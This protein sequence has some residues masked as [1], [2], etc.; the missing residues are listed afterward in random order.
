MD[1]NKFNKLREKI[2]KKDF[3]GKNENLD[4]WLYRF[5][6]FG[7]VSS[8]FFAIFLVFPALYKAFNVY[9]GF[10]IWDIIL[11][12]MTTFAFLVSFEVIK[13][14]LIRNFSHDLCLNKNKLSFKLVGWFI[15]SLSIITL[16]FYLSINGSKNLAESTVFNETKHNEMLESKMDSIYQ[17]Y[18]KLR[19]PY[20]DEIEELRKSNRRSREIQASTTNA[21]ERRENEKIISNNEQI[22]GNYEEKLTIYSNAVKEEIEELKTNLELIQEKEINKEFKII[23]LF[24]IIVIFNELIIIS[25]VYFREYYEY[26]LYEINLVKYE[27]LY[28]KRDRFR[29]LL[30]FIYHEGKL[31]VGERVIA[32]L[33]LKAILK[34]RTNL[35]SINKLVDE[36]MFEMDR[37]G[38]F[39]TV[40]KRRFI[41]L[42]YEDALKLIDNYD[43]IFMVLDNIK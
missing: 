14:Y 28:N 22:I 31:N 12:N 34:E 39:N 15:V 10:G 17:K 25:G 2:Q 20:I 38:V 1:I 27:K 32:G 19:K 43:D 21:W 33:E 26:N 13:R 35:S 40:G 37:L 16:S 18:E 8:I 24:I 5:S 42:P 9:L 29:S 4:K 6:F 11:A 23:Y 41:G 30:A 3:E 36:F 7:N